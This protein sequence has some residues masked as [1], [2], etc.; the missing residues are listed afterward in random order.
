MRWEQHGTVVDLETGRIHRAGES[1]H[2][3]PN[4]VAL[5]RRLA[6]TPGEVVGRSDLLTEVW[7][8]HPR[9]RSRAIDKAVNRLRS[10][11]ESNPQRPT[12]LHTL[13]GRGFRF[14]PPGLPPH[15]SHPDKPHTPPR[16]ARPP[17]LQQ[18]A[19]PMLGRSDEREAVSAWLAGDGRVLTVLGVGGIGKT[20]LARWAT[21]EAQARGQLLGWCDVAGITDEPGLSA[22]LAK[23][24]GVQLGP[25]ATRPTLTK[26]LAACGQAVLVLDDF[27]GVAAHA[28]PALSAWLAGS[29]VRVLITSRVRVRLSAPPE[30][31]LLLGPL[32]HTEAVDLLVRRSRWP[33]SPAV[34]QIARKVEGI[35]HALE[36]AGAQGPLMPAKLVL[37]RLQAMLDMPQPVVGPAHHRTLHAAMAWSWD[38]LNPSQKHA[39]SHLSAVGGPLCVAAAEAVV[40]RTDALRMVVD[41]AE[42]SLLTWQGDQ[43]GMYA[44]V[45]H[46]ARAHAPDVHGAHM[47]LARFV[48]ADGSAAVEACGVWSAG[49]AVRKLVSVQA[50]EGA[51]DA[52]LMAGS[53]DLA[54]PVVACLAWMQLGWVPHMH[55]IDRL[56]AALALP[57]TCGAARLRALVVLAEVAGKA[58]RWDTVNRVGPELKDLARVVSPELRAFAW[59][60]WANIDRPA[61]DRLETARQAV[62]FCSEG[63]ARAMALTVL[64]GNLQYANDNDT[65]ERVL[66][67]A[68]ALYRDQNDITGVA[69]AE[70][71]RWRRAASYPDARHILR[72]LERLYPQVP[73]GLVQLKLQIIRTLWLMNLRRAEEGLQPGLQAKQ[74]A[75]RQGRWLDVVASAYFL[76]NC[77]AM[78]GQEARA[79][80]SVV[81]ALQM[82]ERI[83][84]THKPWVLRARALLDLT[85]GGITARTRADL[86]TS[87]W[88]EPRQRVDTA[89][90]ALVDRALGNEAA[91]TEVLDSIDVPWIRRVLDG[92]RSEAVYEASDSQVDCFFLVHALDGP[93]PRKDVP[94]A[95]FNLM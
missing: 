51:A 12:W 33:R 2:L 39:L 34:E 76:T 70:L 30:E 31:V 65:A 72:R 66:D 23:L 10:K 82:V 83:Q 22:R 17:G 42:S 74:T 94:K 4:E 35:P 24:L 29:R 5:L 91:A 44:V 75:M 46:F 93:P 78:L 53:G 89:F 38:L 11:L 50:V 61:D 37:H 69:H 52:A 67:E 7:G 68:V 64:G 3:T 90:V 77:W 41:L 16:A 19:R 92:D 21:A 80:A 63:P 55:I 45:R 81:D 25:E 43:V 9:T 58:G 28:G 40:D 60:R 85:F 1:T 84:S 54:C 20:R 86:T 15:P 18:V 59:S 47:R 6:Q 88:K 36:L 48:A 56:E 13:R 79:R 49:E 87:T 14:T 95:V 62:A 57:T 32:D 8:Y 73:A 27:E 26:A 71:I